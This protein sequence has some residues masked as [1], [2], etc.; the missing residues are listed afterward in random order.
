MQFAVR[1]RWTVRLTSAGFER[2]DGST[3]TDEELKKPLEAFIWVLARFGDES[4]LR[5]V[6]SF[7]ELHGPENPGEPQYP[8]LPPN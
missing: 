8:N 5:L 2:S 7:P 1:E 4:W 3:P 6:L